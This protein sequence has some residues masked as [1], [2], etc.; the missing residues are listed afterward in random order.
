M[1]LES[2]RVTL[3]ARSPRVCV[4]RTITGTH[5]TGS[6]FAVVPPRRTRRRGRGRRQGAERREGQACRKV[7]QELRPESRVLHRQVPA[8]QQDLDEVGT[9]RDGPEETETGE[10]VRLGL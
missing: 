7:R 1:L 5:E 10:E 9:S 2:C 4:C 8:R 6:H 3:I